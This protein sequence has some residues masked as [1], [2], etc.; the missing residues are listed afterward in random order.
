[1]SPQPGPLI[2]DEKD[3]NVEDEEIKEMMMKKKNVGEQMENHLKQLT[4]TWNKNKNKLKNFFLV[5]IQ[6]PE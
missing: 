3:L 6:N 5:G 4:H 2:I 1:M